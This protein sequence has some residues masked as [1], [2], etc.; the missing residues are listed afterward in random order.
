[1]LALL[2]IVHGVKLAEVKPIDLLNLQSEI[3]VG[4]ASTDVRTEVRNGKKRY[5]F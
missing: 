1:M 4:K 3:A 5:N 2:M